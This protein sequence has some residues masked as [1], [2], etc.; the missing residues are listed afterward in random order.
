MPGMS[1]T[2]FLCRVKDLY[3]DTVRVA[4]TGFADLATVTAAVNQGS[5]FKFLTKPWGEDLLRDSIRQ[6]F[7]HHQLMPVSETVW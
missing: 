7:R 4:L 3:P 6:A 5:I 2:E 1:G